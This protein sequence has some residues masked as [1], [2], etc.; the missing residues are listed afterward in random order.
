MCAMPATALTIKQETKPIP[1]E[2]RDKHIKTRHEEYFIIP[3]KCYFLFLLIFQVSQPFELVG[4]DLIGKV[5][6]TEAGNQYTAVMIDYFTKW[7][8][9]YLCH[10]KQQQM[11]H[12]TL[13]SSFMAL[14]PLSES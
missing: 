14:G 11:L 13:L 5:V 12:N 7:S 4:M 1:I 2:V 9:A 6:K 8:E 3:Q 10:L